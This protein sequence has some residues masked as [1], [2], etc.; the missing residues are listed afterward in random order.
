MNL[1][2]ILFREGERLG[3]GSHDYRDQ[4]A[5]PSAVE[6]KKPVMRMRG[7]ARISPVVQRPK[8]NVP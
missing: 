6:P 4:E 8:N 7:T 2:T 3:I 5:P 1:D